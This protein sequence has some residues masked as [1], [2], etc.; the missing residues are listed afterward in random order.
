MNPRPG[1]NLGRWF[2]KQIRDDNDVVHE[3][4]LPVFWAR[5]LH[6]GDPLRILQMGFEAYLDVE[7][8]HGHAKGQ[9]KFGEES[10]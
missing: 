7:R 9:P 6:T 3:Q 10:A 1:S 2:G 8:N 5:S 4:Q